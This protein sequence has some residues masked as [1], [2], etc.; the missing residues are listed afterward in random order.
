MAYLVQ[1]DSKFTHI[2]DMGELMRFLGHR[3][4]EWCDIPLDQNNDSALD[5]FINCLRDKDFGDIATVYEIIP[6]DKEAPYFDCSDIGNTFTLKRV[7]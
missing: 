4:D 5:L 2:E 7:M 6:A 1:T 3:V